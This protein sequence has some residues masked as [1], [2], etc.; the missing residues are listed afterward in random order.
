MSR[1]LIL[2]LK[3]EYFEAIRK[4]EK[5]EEFREA[6]PYWRKRL[7]GQHFDAIELT[8]GYPARDDKA[9]RIR[10]QWRGYLER[11]ITHPHFGSVPVQVFAIDVSG[12]AMP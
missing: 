4:G 10:K 6:T 9:R 7:V 12:L 11:T 1:T 2:P 5:A 3:R 8:L